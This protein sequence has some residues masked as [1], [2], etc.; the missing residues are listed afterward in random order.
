ML[1]TYPT[2]TPIDEQP[3]KATAGLRSNAALIGDAATMPSNPPAMAANKRVCT[4][5]LL[6]ES[7]VLIA[8]K[9]LRLKV[10]VVPEN[11]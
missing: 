7:S 10:Q 9:T 3:I 4:E 2:A 11:T 6:L 5:F 1:A 8:Q